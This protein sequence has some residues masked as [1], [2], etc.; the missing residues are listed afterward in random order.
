[1]TFFQIFEIEIFRFPP[2]MWASDPYSVRTT[3]GAESFHKQYNS[4]FHASH[5]NIIL[6]IN[7]LRKIQIDSVSKINSCFQD[8]INLP[9][10]D[11]IEKEEF[12]TMRLR[13]Y[14]DKIITRKLVLIALGFRFAAKKR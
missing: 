14:A 1:M 2:Q 3:N 6:V 5:P 8:K 12:I 9:R 11:E 7:V 4:E 10:K 13:A